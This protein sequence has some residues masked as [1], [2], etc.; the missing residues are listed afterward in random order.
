MCLANSNKSPFGYWIRT[1][2]SNIFIIE[3]ETIIGNVLFFGLR[4]G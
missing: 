2:P 4:F 1:A 3:V